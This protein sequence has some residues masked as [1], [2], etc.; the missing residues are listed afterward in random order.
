MPLLNLMGW[1]NPQRKKLRLLRKTCRDEA[2]IR[3][4]SRN[5][6]AA[7]TSDRPLSGCRVLVSRAKKQAGVLSSAL[8]ELGCDVIE[9]P[10]IE[11]RKPSSYRPLDAAL[12]NLATYDWLILTSVNGV[13]ALFERMEHRKLD[14]E[15]LAKLKDRSHRSCDQSCHRTAWAYGH[16]HAE[17]IRCGIGGRI[18]SSSGQRESACCWCAPKSPAM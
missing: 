12:R 9:I 3:Q 6:I 10:F 15:A 14:P 16:G 4:S 2:S 8:R 5:P 1:K 7:P 11:I 17:G 13:E 18:A